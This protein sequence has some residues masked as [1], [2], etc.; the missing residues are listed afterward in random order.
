[1]AQPSF[2]PRKP[3]NAPAFYESP[4]RTRGS[5]QPSRPG[6]LTAPGQP[7]GD[8]NG[9]QGPDQ[10]YALLLA[11]N[12]R[13]QVQLP[14]GSPLSEDAVLA[15]C[16]S[17][18]LKRASMFGRAPVSADMGL[19][20]AVWGFFDDS[21]DAELVSLRRELFAEAAHS[22]A[23]ASHI[24]DFVPTETLRMLPDEV[25]EAKPSS[26]ALLEIPQH[27]QQ[28]QTHSQAQTQPQTSQQPQH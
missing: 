23:H 7:Q 13:S 9:Y 11:E 19:A 16:L 5:W 20:L 21:P 10:G 8:G 15:G 1:M 25:C 3:R 24:A 28:Q 26:L 2:V 27:S 22:P 6:D 4:Q 12:F 17:V 14:E 18:A